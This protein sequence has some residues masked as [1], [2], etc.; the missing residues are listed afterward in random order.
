MKGDQDTRNWKVTMYSYYDCSNSC[1]MLLIYYVVY[2]TMAL[3]F[4][5]TSSVA[6]RCVEES[7]APAISDVC[8]IVRGQIFVSSSCY[9]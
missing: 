5:R 6:K 2:L 4:M 8:P 3:S 7:T 1:E 9:I